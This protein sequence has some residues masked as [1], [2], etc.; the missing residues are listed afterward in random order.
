MRFIL[1]PFKFIGYKATTMP[2]T[3]HRGGVFVQINKF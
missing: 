3:R 2:N 1:F